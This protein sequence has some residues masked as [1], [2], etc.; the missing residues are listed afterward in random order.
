MG[1]ISPAPARPS[2]V[3]TLAPSAWAVRTVQDLTDA[4][5]SRTVHAPHEVVSQPTLVP[6][7]PSTSRR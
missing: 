2:M 1:C 3:V 7:R 5:S 4:P 6:V